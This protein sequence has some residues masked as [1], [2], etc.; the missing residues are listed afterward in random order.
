M[1]FVNLSIT[2]DRELLRGRILALEEGQL[3]V[4][5]TMDPGVVVLGGVS[6]LTIIGLV[7]LLAVVTEIDL[8]DSET[9]VTRLGVLPGGP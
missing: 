1:A 9:L 3:V 7:T 2:A 4:G 5:E 8:G 6:V